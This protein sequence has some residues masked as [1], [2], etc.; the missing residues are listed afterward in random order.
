MLRLYNQYAGVPTSATTS[1]A[2]LLAA[3][4]AGYATPTTTMAHMS[5]AAGMTVPSYAAAY[6]IPASSAAGAATL[7]PTY[8]YSA[9]GSATPTGYYAD[10][11]ALAKEAAQKYHANAIKMAAAVNANQLS[12]KPL[13][14]VAA[15]GMAG[16]QLGKAYMTAMPGSANAI[17]AQQQQLSLL[18]AHHIAQ[19]QHAAA[20]AAA[21]RSALAASSLSSSGM[22]TPVGTP[23][24]TPTPGVAASG[25]L[26]RPSSAAGNYISAA[27]SHTALRPQAVQLTAAPSASN[28]PYAAAAAAAAM[29][30]QG[31]FYPAGMMAAPATPA[32]PYAAIGGIPTAMPTAAGMPTALS[33]I[34]TAPASAA[35][36]AMVLNPYK[37]MKTS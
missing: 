9:Y 4:H 13:T 2:N 7:T 25:L 18:Q 30:Q 26:T 12:G 31:F 37:K 28:S 11:S 21:T 34:T 16:L 23:V 1:Y 10:A 8:A 19:A 29:Q 36:S 14:A 33:G 24:H 32:Y 5:A 15:G 22:S 35:G 3:S 20:A 6:G 27:T 17:V